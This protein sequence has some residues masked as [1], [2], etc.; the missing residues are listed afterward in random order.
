MRLDGGG[1]FLDEAAEVFGGLV[2]VAEGDGV[3]LVEDAAVVG[4]EDDLGGDGDEIAGGLAGGGVVG[5]G[6]DGLGEDGAA[7]GGVG[8]GGVGVE[9]AVVGAGVEL[10]DDGLGEGHFGVVGLGFGGEDGDGEG[11]DVRGDVGGRAGL[12][13]AA[14]GEGRRRRSV[15]G[16]RFMRLFL[17]SHWWEFARKYS[18]VVESWILR[19]VLGSFS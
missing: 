16:R 3:V 8:A 7:E 2:L 17:L 19:G 11:A 4:G 18:D 15:R 12:V 14:S 6:G 10:A 1:V 5:E 9:D 13:V